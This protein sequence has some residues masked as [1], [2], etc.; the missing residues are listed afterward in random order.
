MT[1][2]WTPLDITRTHMYTHWLI[3]NS[4]LIL[5]LPTHHPP[6]EHSKMDSSCWS[7]HHS[8]MHRHMY[9]HRALVNFQVTTE[10]AY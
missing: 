7:P 2:Q 9:V 4:A 6:H 8:S 10:M 3:P 1:F 5:H